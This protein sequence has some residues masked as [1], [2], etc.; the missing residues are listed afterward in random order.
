MAEI[1]FTDEFKDD[2]NTAIKLDLWR[3]L[4]AYTKPYKRDVW[5]LAVSS[6]LTGFLEVA[7]PVITKWMVDDIE[8]NGVDANFWL[9]GSLFLSTTVLLVVCVMAFI[10]TASKLRVFASHDLRKAAF[11]NLQR[12]SFSYFDYRPVG[13]LVARMTSDCEKL[14]NIVAWGLMDLLWGATTMIAVGFALFFWHWKLALLV[15]TLIPVI[16]WISL[17]FRRSM[18]NSARDVRTANSR[19][20]GSFNE[21]ILGVLTSKTYVREHANLSD[22]QDLT[23]RMYRASVRNLTIAAFYVPVIVVASS[24]SYGVTLAYGGSE[25]LAGALATGS[26][27]S[28]ML[29][30][31]Y[32]YDPISVM[33]HWF[34]EMQ[35]AQASAERVLGIINAEPSIKDSASVEQALSLNTP[36]TDRKTIAEDG[37]SSLIR[38]IEVRNLSF[39]YLPG[40]PILRNIDFSANEGESI[41]FVGPTGGGKSTLVNVICRFYEPSSGQILVDGVD[42]RNRGLRWYRSNIGMVL[43]Q[44]HVFSGTIMENIRYGRLDATDDE[45]MD[46]ARVVGAHEFIESMADG[47]QTLAG[48]SGSR[49]SAGQKQLVSFARAILANPQILI[50]DEATSSVDTD[51]ERR[52][53]KGVE[54]LL[55]GRISLVIAHRLSTIRNADRII[56]IDNGEIAESG[57]H[58]TLLA[59]RGKYFGLY[60]Q[61]SLSQSFTAALEH[62][63]LITPT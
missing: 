45:V 27:I 59:K 40:Q 6:I 14:T 51:T 23:Q 30:V 17:K 16:G 42:Y 1:D 13:W 24:L 12:Q 39:E 44:A 38:G 46:A 48:E 29:L 9:W 19:I 50:L 3:Q 34:A 25:L 2:A 31:G 21:N 52:I 22:F 37:G 62:Q 56:Y 28:F 49:L 33:G 41:A 60:S 11:Q 54:K 18:L 15:L 47:Y 58:A 4:F 55:A 8:R 10:W 32:F 35:M 53:Q 57:S 61:Q 63:D 7:D 43:Q 26:L 5:I 20:T 36:I